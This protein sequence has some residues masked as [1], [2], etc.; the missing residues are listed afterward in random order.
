M[1]TIELSQ[2]KVAVVDDE[3]FEWLSQWKWC[4]V[5]NHHTFYAIRKERLADGKRQTVRMHREIMNVEAGIK[6][7]H[8]DGDGLN[9]TRNNLRAATNQQN[10]WN[11]L[12][13]S[14]NTSGYKGIYRVK[15]KWRAEIKVNGTKK[16]L[17]YFSSAEEAA[18]QYDVVAKELHGEF[19]RLNFPSEQ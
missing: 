13:P 14:H 15:S 8:K 17:G 18:R 1:K 16:S 9:N 7:D 19:A 4:A 11:R 3:D 6:V 10:L 2:G 5:R 12:L